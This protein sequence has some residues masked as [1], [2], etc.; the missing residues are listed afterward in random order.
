MTNPY[1]DR[2]DFSIHNLLFSFIFF[3]CVWSLNVTSH[4]L[5]HSWE[6]LRGVFLYRDGLLTIELLEQGYVAIRLQSLLPKVY[7][8]HEETVAVYPSAQ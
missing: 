1:D 2:D 5:Y 3:I 8:R 4:T 7:G 6:I